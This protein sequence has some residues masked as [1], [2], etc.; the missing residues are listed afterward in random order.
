M[1]D[2]KLSYQAY[3]NR[4]DENDG[5]FIE[6]IDN[7]NHKLNDSLIEINILHDQ[8]ISFKE[9]NNMIPNEWRKFEKQGRLKINITSVY[10]PQY[11][12][13]KKCCLKLVL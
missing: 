7:A 1:T 13:T 12:Y 10:I 11:E 4:L 3:V 2:I 9:I 5:L 8:Y 6:L